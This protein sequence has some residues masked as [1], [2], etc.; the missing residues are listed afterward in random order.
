MKTEAAK[1]AGSAP[2]SA[3]SV[4]MPPAEA[5]ITI[6]SFDIKTVLAPLEVRVTGLDEVGVKIQYT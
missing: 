1:S 4:W 2:I 5:P 6:I 3:R